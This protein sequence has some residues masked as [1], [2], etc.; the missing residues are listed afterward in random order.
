VPARREE[1]LLAMSTRT[2]Q[3]DRLIHESYERHDVHPVLKR[4]VVRATHSALREV[5]PDKY[6]EKCHG[7]AIA[8]F[9]ILRTLC[10]RSVICGGTVSWMFGGIDAEGRPFQN[11]CGFWSPNPN[12]PTP[13]AWVVTEFGSLIDL[14]CSYYHMTFRDSIGGIKDHDVIP[15]IWMKT[16]HLT[17]LP[18][19][20]YAT[21]ARFSNI[22]LRGCDELARRLVGQALMEFWS[23]PAVEQL[24]EVDGGPEHRPG[25][26]ADLLLLDDP[27]RLEDL[28]ASNSW[29]ARNSRLPPNE[30]AGFF[31]VT[32]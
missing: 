22:N 26:A 13:H 21:A 30:N 15:M 12:L 4:L 17:E 2:R 8:T 1:T 20:Q 18:A 24:I 3:I 9:M 16:E 6:Y 28:R 5:V 19:V 27:I 29:V 14:T 11:R 31:S 7:A 23:D 25:D 32:G 10:V